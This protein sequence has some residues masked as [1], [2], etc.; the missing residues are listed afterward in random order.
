M[1][2][3]IDQKRDR[4]HEIFLE[5]FPL[6]K[7]ASR[8]TLYENVM[9][10]I[11]S[12]IKNGSWQPGSKM[13][14]ELALAEQFQISRSSVREAMKALSVY[15]IIESRPGHGTFIAPDAI[16]RIANNELLHSLSEDVSIVEKMELRVIMEIQMVEWVTKNATLEDLD[17]LEN[18]INNDIQNIDKLQE[19]I[20]QTR[21]KFHDRLA[22]IAGNGIMI[23]LIRSIRA[24]LEAHRHNY[25]VLP[26][27]HWNKMMEEHRAILKH[28]RSRNVKKAREAMVKHLLQ[29]MEDIMG[30]SRSAIH[31]EDT[32]VHM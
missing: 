9:T 1:L 29:D 19:T 3:K 10:Q 7:P 20:L 5:E 4:V 22:E 2:Q 27:Q 25:L 16:R 11:I 14:G 30:Y 13:D 23:R 18:T 24:E 15:K 17:S 21:T 28:I 8:S 12:A 32:L 31:L 26:E 6:F